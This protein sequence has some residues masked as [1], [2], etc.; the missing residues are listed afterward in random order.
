[1][2][3]CLACSAFPSQLGL[4]GRA[5]S[6]LLTRVSQLRTGI[7]Q[8]SADAAGRLSARDLWIFAHGSREQTNAVHLWRRFVEFF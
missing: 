8:M 6:S 3:S 2:A 4:Q 5:I 7:M 1:M